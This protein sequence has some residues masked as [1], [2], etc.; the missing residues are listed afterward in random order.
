MGEF[1]GSLQ[2]VEPCECSSQASLQ[3]RPR[4]R[5]LDCHDSVFLPIQPLPSTAIVYPQSD[6]LCDVI[7]GK[8]CP[9]ASSHVHWAKGASRVVSKDVCRYCKSTQEEILRLLTSSQIEKHVWEVKCRHRASPGLPCG[10]LVRRM[11]WQ[12]SLTCFL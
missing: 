6:T 7:I 11:S 9:T 3:R 2:T 4:K 10:I 5:Q 8:H 1:Y 12:R